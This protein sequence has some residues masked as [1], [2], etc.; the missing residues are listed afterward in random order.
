MTRL[1][2]DDTGKRFFETGVDRGV[3]YVMDGNGAYPLGV[4]WNGLSSVTESPAGAEPSPLYGDNIKY[5]TLMSA[6]EFG[7]TLEAYNYPNEFG[8][9]DG[10]GGFAPGGK[11]FQQSRK[12]FGLVYRTK[13]GNDV[14][15]QDLGYKLHL[16]YGCLSSPSEKAYT[17]VNDSP[18]A[19]TFSWEISTTPVNFTGFQPTSLVVIDSTHCRP[20]GLITLENQLFGAAGIVPNLPLP[21]AIKMILGDYGGRVLDTNPTGYWTL[22]DASG[23]IAID[24]KGLGNGS[25][26]GV[27]LGHPGMGDG[28]MS[29][30]FP[31]SGDSWMHFY[32]SAF[33]AI[34]NGNLFSFAGWL[35][36]ENSGV[37]TDGEARD[38]IHV[39]VDVDNVFYV[40]KH[41]TN[42]NIQFAR[43]AGGVTKEWAT[44]VIGS[45]PV[46][47]DWFHLAVTC[48]QANDSLKS[49]IN[50]IDVTPVISG[51]GSWVG[52]LDSSYSLLG[53]SIA[54]SGIVMHRWYGWQEHLIYYN[55]QLTPIEVTALATK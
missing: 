1:N 11:I 27:T 54:Y 48:N 53:G 26:S 40:R 32:S 45:I 17:S 39:R 55:R 50:G 16:L 7:I 25:Y 12:K 47:T 36:V 44:T 13:L 20:G 3:L 4:A 24:E 51:N 5:L 19:I 28:R 41:T 23:T 35:K 29:V 10:S 2:W 38:W 15:G 42:N 52:S 21:D 14:A 22:G 30:H 9:C 43:I 46:L 18:E 31:G 34:F 33:G 37:W 49:Y 8:Q 6:E